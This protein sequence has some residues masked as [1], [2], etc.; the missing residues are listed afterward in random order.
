MSPYE[1]SVQLLLTEQLKSVLS[2]PEF[3]ALK[4]KIKNNL[5]LKELLLTTVLM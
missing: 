3:E 2:M 4:Q 5:R 1:I